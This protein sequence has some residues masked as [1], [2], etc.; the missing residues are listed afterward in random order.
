M[1]SLAPDGEQSDLE[2]LYRD[3]RA[4]WMGYLRGQIRLIFILSH[5]VFHCVVCHWFAGRV[6]HWVCWQAY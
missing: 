6:W 1:F 3:I 4:V 5:L 2:H